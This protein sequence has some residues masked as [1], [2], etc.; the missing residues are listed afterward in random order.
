MKAIQW[1]AAS[2]A[3]GVSIVVV[4][5]GQV[6]LD[7]VQLN[8]VGGAGG[9]NCAIGETLCGVICTDTRKDPAHCGDCVT[10]CAGSS[11]FSRELNG[12]EVSK[13]ETK[14]R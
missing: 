6:Y 3:A 11:V 12:T 8:G 10:A 13:R 2:F 1:I 5:C 4:S 14:I 9:G 7:G